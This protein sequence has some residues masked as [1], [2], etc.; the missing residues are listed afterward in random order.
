[1]QD[2]IKDLHI[3]RLLA[4]FLVYEDGE[5][6]LLIIKN[7]DAT[8]SYCAE[9]EY[10]KIYE[11]CMKSG[12]LNDTDSV[13]WMISQGLWTKEK[14]SRLIE[15]RDSISNLKI[16]IFRN[17]IKDS[18]VFTLKK[19]IRRAEK[20]ISELL[21]QKNAYYS[22]TC[23]GVASYHKWIY[24][25]ERCTYRD[26][27]IRYN[28]EE[29]DAQYI[30]NYWQ[31][32]TL[33]DT[34]L[35]QIAKYDVWLNI[36]HSSNKQPFTNSYLSDEQKKIIM[37]SRMY[38]NIKESSECP[39]DDVIEDDDALD[40]WLLIQQKNNQKNKTS[41][42]VDS[43]V[44]NANKH[45]EIFVPVGSQEEAR[46][47]FELNNAQGSL[48]YKTRMEQIKKEGVIEHG[49]LRDVQLERQLLA[50]QQLSPKGI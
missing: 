40:G 37:W 15:L 7:P 31:S 27:D 43:L 9:Y 28:F 29:L 45:A 22:N 46:K 39:A 34:E 10:C 3:K 25:I 4:N 5:V 8:I 2:Y 33:N 30:L 47:I 26:N 21:N 19:N 49:R 42:M 23:D 44:G 48:T 17:W 12:I 20:E 32:N 6:G 16:E 50:N 11:E 13:N 1:M 38:D 14:E 35:R 36:W 41:K 24:L 18:T